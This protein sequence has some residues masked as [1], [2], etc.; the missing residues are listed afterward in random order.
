MGTESRKCITVPSPASKTVTNPLRPRLSF[1]ARIFEKVKAT[2]FR[3]AEE[4]RDPV[5]V[6]IHRQRPRPQ[7]HAE[8][9]DEAGVVVR[10]PVERL[11]GGDASKGGNQPAKEREKGAW[12][13]AWTC[14]KVA[15]LIER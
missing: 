11:R 2:V 14:E 4:I 6:E 12:M 9:H 13:S 3:A 5:A 10:Q 15:T 7:P 8:I 1:G